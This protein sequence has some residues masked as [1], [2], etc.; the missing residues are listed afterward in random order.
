MAYELQTHVSE[1]QAITDLSHSVSANSSEHSQFR[2]AAYMKRLSAVGLALVTM[3]AL[4]GVAAAQNPPTDRE[5]IN[6][7]VTT[8]FDNTL[9]TCLGTIRIVG[10]LETTTKAGGAVGGHVHSQISSV[11]KDVTAVNVAT[12]EQYRVQYMERSHRSYEYPG[13]GQHVAGTTNRLRISAPGSGES[14]FLTGRWKYRQDQ[15]GA[16][17]ENELQ[18]EGGCK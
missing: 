11:L 14:F 12:G 15:S 4:P 6:T 5:R 1:G 18:N 8:P 10:T 7:T 9:V 3:A 13:T 2:R 16:V 17:V